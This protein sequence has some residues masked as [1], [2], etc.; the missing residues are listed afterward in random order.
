MGFKSRVIKRSRNWPGVKFIITLECYKGLNS[1][2]YQLDLYLVS[3]STSH[4]DHSTSFGFE[5][6]FEGLS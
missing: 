1:S 4:L 2:P 3:K 5:S 6:Y